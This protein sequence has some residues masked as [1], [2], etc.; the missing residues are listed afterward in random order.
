M[1]AFCFSGPPEYHHGDHRGD[2]HLERAEKIV[3]VGPACVEERADA[4]LRR[5]HCEVVHVE[6]GH[7]RGAAAIVP[8]RRAFT[9]QNLPA[10][11]GA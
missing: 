1:P 7:M 10:D 2:A 6:E 9:L 8:A 3:A 5:D 4:G 11:N